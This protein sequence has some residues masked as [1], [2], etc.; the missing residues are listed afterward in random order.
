MC[1]WVFVF[2]WRPEEGVLEVKVV[3]NHLMWVLGTKTQTLC[4]SWMCSYP[5]SCFSGPLF[6]ILNLSLNEQFLPA[7]TTCYYSPILI[8]L[9][10]AFLTLLNQ[11]VLE[12]AARLFCTH[13]NSMP[14]WK[15]V[16]KTGML[17]TTSKAPPSPA[18]ASLFSGGLLFS[19]TDLWVEVGSP[20]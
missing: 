14:P 15:V 8:F 3:V 18:G 10:F 4:G 20:L 2:V 12:V 11:S 16:V 7:L 17:G 6:H 13:Q 19:Q 1:V 5:Q 9:L